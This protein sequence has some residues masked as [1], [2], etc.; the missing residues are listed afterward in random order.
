MSPWFTRRTAGTPGPERLPDVFHRDGA[1]ARRHR[2]IEQ[3]A[4]ERYA[5]IPF[6]WTSSRLEAELNSISSAPVPRRPP[7]PARHA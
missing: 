1:L 2:A 6:G 4:V 7:A 3:R 5:E